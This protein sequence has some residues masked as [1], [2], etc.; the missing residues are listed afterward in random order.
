MRKRND[1][2]ITQLPDELR[3]DLKNI[4]ANNGIP[5]S[6]MLKPHLRDIRDSYPEHLRKPKK[7][8]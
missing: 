6:T 7:D 1:F 2:V 5:L 8:F 3:N 4:A